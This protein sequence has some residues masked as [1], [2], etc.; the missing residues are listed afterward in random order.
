MH[1]STFRNLGTIFGPFFG[2]FPLVCPLGGV[3]LDATEV[4]F[5]FEADFYSSTACAWR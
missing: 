1:A 2:A 5:F 3:E 4:I